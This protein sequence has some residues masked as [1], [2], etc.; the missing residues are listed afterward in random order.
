[1]Q[2]GDLV[3]LD[4]D[5]GVIRDMCEDDP[6]EYEQELKWIGVITQMDTDYNDHTEI[7]I[8]HWSH[9][10]HSCPEYVDYLMVVEQPD[11]KCP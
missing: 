2:V 1:M 9:K 4:P 6:D 5:S 8:V 11:K 10:T 3:K 7:A